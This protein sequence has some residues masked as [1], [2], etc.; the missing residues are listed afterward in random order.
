MAAASAK[1]RVV[2]YT[3][4]AVYLLGQAFDM[5]WHS[6]NVSFV[7]EPPSEV[8]V[9]HSGMYVGAATVAVAG[10]LLLGRPQER[11]GGALALTG[12]LVQLAGFG[13]DTWAHGHGY[14]KAL[15]HD[16]WWYGFAVVVVGAVLLEYRRWRGS[17][18]R[19][20]DEEPTTT[21][22]EREHS[23]PRISGGPH[24]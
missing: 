14:S 8:F 24:A 7:P 23:L 22:L 3:G 15:Y 21:A 18:V 1:G 16:L 12:G 4:A 6:R 19:P 5:L 17:G 2:L 13:L 11:P 9:I 20:A 10:L